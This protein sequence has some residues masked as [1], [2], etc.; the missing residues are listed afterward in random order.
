VGG[1]EG[2]ISHVRLATPVVIQNKKTIN[3]Q[4]EPSKK[5]INGQKETE[6]KD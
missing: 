2:W 4:K 6:Q 1:T 3:D 5:T